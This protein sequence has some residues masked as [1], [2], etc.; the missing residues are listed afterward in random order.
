MNC[1]NQYTKFEF[2]TELFESRITRDSNNMKKLSYTD[3]CERFYLMLLAMELL[4][5]FK[6]TN[7]DIIK[8]AKKTKS[9]NDFKNFQTNSTDLHNFIYFIIGDEKVLQKLKDH[10]KAIIDQKERSFPLM[11]VNR[12][13]RQLS[14]GSKP[15]HIYNLF[16]SI[17]DGL[18][19]KNNEYKSIRRDVLSI[20]KSSLSQIKTSITKLIHASRSKLKSSDLIN[21]L[22]RISILK[23]LESISAKDNKITGRNLLYISDMVGSSNVYLAL[24][25][26]DRMEKGQAI[27]SNVMKAFRPAI[28]L[29]MDIIRGGPAYITALKSLQRQAIKSNNG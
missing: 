21:H 3:C 9:Y 26:L 14:S 24:D 23:D 7:N 13:L 19:I 4:R 10:Q 17:E 18:K 8:Y 29:L 16:T 22:E 27:P 25:F 1:D 11:A 2:I 5:N 28:R 12:Y 20:K 6:E 15:T